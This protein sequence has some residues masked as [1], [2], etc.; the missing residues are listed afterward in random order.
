MLQ[1]HMRGI[2]GWLEQMMNELQSPQT[3]REL[4]SQRIADPRERERLARALTV[5]AITLHRW[6][7][8]ISNPRPE[9]LLRLLE[10]LSFKESDQLLR[11]FKQETSNYLTLQ[12]EIMTTK[13]I[14][15]PA[16][17]CTHILRMSRTMHKDIFFVTLCGLILAQAIK[18]FDPHLKGIAIIVVKCMPPSHGKVRSLRETVGLGTSPWDSDLNQSYRL[19]GA[20]SLVGNTFPDDGVK[21]NEDLSNPLNRAAG[22]R[23]QW[24]VSAAATPIMRANE[25]AGVLLASSTQPDYFDE[26]LKDL[27]VQYAALIASLFETHE[28]YPIQHIALSALP[29]Y[30]EQRPLLDDFQGSVSKIMEEKARNHNPVTVTQAENLAWQAIEAALLGKQDRLVRGNVEGA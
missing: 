19:L 6:A 25:F 3:W 23:D 26:P 2:V 9:K 29:S 27:L 21:T 22:Y 10:M 17:F 5:N 30:V 1:M 20:E 8:G 4:L 11:L 16:D 13:E 28:F 15:I 18:Q 14:T 7:K 12:D 24:E